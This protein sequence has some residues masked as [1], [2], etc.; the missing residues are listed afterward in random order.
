MN[1]LLKD[2]INMIKVGS[3]I[4]NV[5]VGTESE[6]DND[7]LVKEILRRIEENY[8]YIKPEKCKQKVK[9]VDFLGIVIGLEELEE[10]EDK[11]IK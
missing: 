1:E 9:K 10:K 3:F 6:K 11:K 5:M 8:L 7:E 4:D 2:L